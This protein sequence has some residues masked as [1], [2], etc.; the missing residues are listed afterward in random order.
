MDDIRYSVRTKYLADQN[1][2]NF[3]SNNI[4]VNMLDSEMCGAYKLEKYII[5]SLHLGAK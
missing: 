2:Q 5:K 4:V 1:E 3:A